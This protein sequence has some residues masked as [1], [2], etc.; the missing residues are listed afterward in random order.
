M[1]YYLLALV[2]LLAAE[3]TNAIA[4]SPESFF[5]HHV[6]NRWDYVQWR[7]GTQ[8][9]FS[10]VLTRDSI[11]AD[12]SH[13]LFYNN[14]GQP[15]YRI[16]TA[17]N[18]FRAPAYPIHGYYLRYKL[19]ADSCEVW[20]NPQSG[21][22]RWAWVARVESASV[23]FQST[24][25]KTFR[26]APGNPC[27]LGSLEED[28][29]ASGFGLIY[30][31]REPN[32]ITYLLGCIIDGDTF[33]ILTTSAPLRSDLPYK[34]RLRQNYP[35]P[36]NP[37]TTIE[38]ESPEATVVTIRVYDLLGRKVAT[39]LDGKVQPGVHRVVWDASG[40][41]GGVYLCRFQSAGQMHTIKMLL[42]K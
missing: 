11:G 3:N 21:S 8:S 13:Y 14:S 38:F 33:G 36:F 15:G 23:F 24:V 7:G 40:L 39:L 31:W 26:Y 27:A 32:D 10:L 34:H 29:L 17:Y 42:N 18:V 28:Q 35:N 19:R 12:G 2:F 25:V 5:P 41:S 22:T 37:S 1:T 6:G 20:E 30:T 16:D 4:Q 9:F